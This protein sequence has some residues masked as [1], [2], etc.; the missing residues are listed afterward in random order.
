MSSDYYRN[1]PSQ[2]N[3]VLQDINIFISEHVL[4]KNQYV[5][6]PYHGGRFK[7]NRYA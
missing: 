7:L 1:L 6:V 3:E 5:V 2:A 4:S